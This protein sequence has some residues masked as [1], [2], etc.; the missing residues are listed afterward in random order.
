M[1]QMIDIL[2]PV[3]NCEKWIEDCLNSLKEQTDKNFEVILI[4]DGSTDNSLKVC[5]KYKEICSMK[6]YSRSNKGVTYTRN[7][8][9]SLSK[10]EYFLFLDSDDI[11]SK[12]TIEI[13]NNLIA[14][15]NLDAIIYD[16]MQFYKSKD[17]ESDDKY[18]IEKY[19]QTEIIKDY[20]ILKRRG[21]IAGILFNKNKWKEINNKF[22]IEK[23]IEDWYPVYYYMYNCNEIKYVHK[24]LY[25]YR[26]IETSAISNTGIDVINNY[27][28]AR[29]SIFTYTVNQH[30]DFFNK[31]LDCF[32]VKTDLDI[33]HEVSKIYTGSVFFK[34]IKKMSCCKTKIIKVLGNQFLTN[35]EKI[36]YILIIFHI[37][38]LMKK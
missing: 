22:V 9:V 28:L 32:N 16:V 26:Q 18:L 33:A 21:Y 35:K 30:D 31:Y 14:E 29:N 5:D 17:L 19:P 20:L 6:I 15:E 27:A 34:E 1:S 11:L 25:F 38:T 4:D 2:I 8:L 12:D 24:Y 36:K 37:Y 3:F 13:L 7:E 10:G 23:Y